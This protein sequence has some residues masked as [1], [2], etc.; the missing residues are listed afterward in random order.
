MHLEVFSSI[1][2]YRSVSSAFFLFFTLI[3]YSNN[4]IETNKTYPIWTNHLASLFMR[5]LHPLLQKIG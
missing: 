5:Y 2:A 4:P 3:D 1:H